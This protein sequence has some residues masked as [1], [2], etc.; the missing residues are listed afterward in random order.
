M[1]DA[2]PFLR[3]TL[4]DVLWLTI[5]GAASLFW[6]VTAGSEVGVTFDEPN[7]VKWGLEHWR[8]G[9][10]RPFMRAGTMPLAIDVQTLP[11]RIWELRRGRPIDEESELGR[12]LPVA[13]AG[14]LV[15]WCL[16]LFYTWRG[17]RALGGAWGG[18]L[19]V[20][21]IACEPLFLAHA[22]LA[23]TDIAVTSCLLAL[24]VE[25][26]MSREARWL[27]RIA[28]PALLFALALLAKA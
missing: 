28:V 10:A 14:T 16:L 2:T 6:C 17:G 13:R 25:F 22:S 19:A 8:T 1:F 24:A 11:L 23:T 26:A 3:R 7:Y 15:F 21:L 4:F 18:R 5:F 12:V 20:A 27:R 9:S